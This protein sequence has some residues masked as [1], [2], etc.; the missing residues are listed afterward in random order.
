MAL[1][2]SLVPTDD[3][4]KCRQADALPLDSTHMLGEFGL[5]VHVEHVDT[6]IG[7][8]STSPFMVVAAATH[9]GQAS[10]QHDVATVSNTTHVLWGKVRRS[11][12]DF[13]H[14]GVIFAQH[15]SCSSS[16][17]LEISTS[18]SSSDS[19]GSSGRLQQLLEQVPLDEDGNLTS[20]GSIGHWTDECRRPACLFAH[21]ERRCRNEVYCRYCH[22]PHDKVRKKTQPCKA[23]RNRYRMHQER[24]LR[25]L[26]RAPELFDP[27]EAPLPQCILND[28]RVRRKT[29]QMLQARQEELMTAAVQSRGT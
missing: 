20:L 23:Q 13:V 9:S 11:R 25:E 7:C 17:S 4:S 2:E 3:S 24:L 21:L 16:G 1:S 26:E 6:S 12:R 10:D 8:S 28:E 19:I 14:S 29:I 22:F 15:S 18:S 27:H 5:G